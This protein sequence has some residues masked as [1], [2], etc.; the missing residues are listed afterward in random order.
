MWPGQIE[1]QVRNMKVIEAVMK[2]FSC[3]M[4]C[5][6]L[7]LQILIRLVMNW[8]PFEAWSTVH[9]SFFLCKTPCSYSWSLNY[10][11][12][13]HFI[14]AVFDRVTVVLLLCSV[15]KSEQKMRDKRLGIFYI[16]FLHHRRTSLKLINALIVGNEWLIGN[17]LAVLS[18]FIACFSLQVRTLT[19]S[20]RRRACML[21]ERIATLSSQRNMLCLFECERSASLLNYFL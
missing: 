6:F 10:L 15:S 4:I 8:A 17:H 18:I 14:P 21:S 13:W 2:I 11:S 20:V 3:S 12:L 9:F 7:D 16:I 1:F 19:P 5:P